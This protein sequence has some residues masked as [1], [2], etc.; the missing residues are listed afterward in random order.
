MTEFKIFKC[1]LST[2][3]KFIGWDRAEKRFDKYDYIMIYKGNTIF[4]G[5]KAL[6]EIFRRFNENK[7]KDYIGSSLSVSDVIV[8]GK[9]VYYVDSIGFHKLED[10]R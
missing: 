7:P 6:N 4:Q 3:Y 9:D 5:V 8:L 1:P 10:W 2:E